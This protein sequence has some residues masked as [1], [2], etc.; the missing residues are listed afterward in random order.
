MGI[1]ILYQ[2]SMMKMFPLLNA[3]AGGDHRCGS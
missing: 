3:Q 2:H 1:E